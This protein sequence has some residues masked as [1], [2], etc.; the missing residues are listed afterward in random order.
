MKL[1]FKNEVPAIICAILLSC[2]QYNKILAQDKTHV[3]EPPIPVYIICPY[4]EDSL[5]A[6]YE[7][8][9]QGNGSTFISA[10]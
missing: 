3:K 5:R 4:H 9:I 10:A 7:G 2:I 6:V 1:I 8:S